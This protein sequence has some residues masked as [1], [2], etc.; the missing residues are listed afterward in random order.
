MNRISKTIKKFSWLFAIFHRLLGPRGLLLLLLLRLRSLLVFLGERDRC[1]C[2]SRSRF[3]F[4]R[5]F[6]RC[7]CRSFRS[8]FSFSISSCRAFR[9]SSLSR[10]RVA[11]WK[12]TEALIVS[13]DQT[14]VRLWGARENRSKN[15]LSKR[16]C[17]FKTF[18]VKVTFI[19][20]FIKNH[21]DN[22][23]FAFSLAFKQRLGQ[24]GNSLF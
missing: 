15:S 19:C 22:Y 21:F 5:S 4:S 2:C 3:S 24:L 6:S 18:L 23:S 20:K 17:K 7:S 11:I 9:L 14:Q 12:Q 1:F 13:R 16:G 8:L 10:S